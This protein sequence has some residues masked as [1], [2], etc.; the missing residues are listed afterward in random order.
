MKIKFNSNDDLHLNKIL[1]FRILTISIRNIFEKDG[2]YYYQGIF[3][4]DCLYGP[5]RLPRNLPECIIFDN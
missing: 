2:K 3:L 1:K 5:K 4:D